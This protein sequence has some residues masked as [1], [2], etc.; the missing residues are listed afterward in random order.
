MSTSPSLSAHMDVHPAAAIFPMLS[1]V[2]LDELAADIKANGQREPIELLD[3]AILDGRNRYAACELAGV[4][5]CFRT[6]DAIESPTRYV[7]SKNLYRR[8]L[9]TGQ[10][11]FIAVEALPLLEDEARM[12][13]IQL[14]GTRPNAEQ[15]P[16]LGADLPQGPVPS[17][18]RAPRARDA[19]GAAVGIS[20]R[21][22]AK[23]KEI[24][25]KAPDLREQLRAG[26]LSLDKAA[27]QVRQREQQAEAAA[28]TTPPEIPERIEV[29]DVTDHIPLDDDSVDL[30]LT[31][32]PYGLDKPYHGIKDAAIGWREFLDDWLV[33]AFRVAK[34][35]GRLALNVPL[36]TSRGGYRATWPEAYNAA[37]AAGWQYR[38]CI[39][40]DKRNST[41]GAHGNGSLNSANAPHPIAEIEMVGLFFKDE[42]G[43]SSES[44]S[45][46]TPEEWQAWGDGVW[47]F[48]GETRPHEHHPAPFPPELPRRLIRYLTR[49]G[50]TVLDPM[51]GSGT[52][53]LVARQLNREGIGFDQAEEYVASSKRRLATGTE[54]EVAA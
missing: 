52:T 44:Y 24:M 16:D 38:T 49:V 31:S 26:T 22:V 11:A 2:E 53:V 50:D 45:D 10:K 47:R 19:A 48:P 39:V 5:P 27:H 13:Q 33:E 30:V 3:D 1:K 6:L 40:W 28:R 36:D 15:H 20:G 35:R 4:E 12:R 37:V 18:T 25:E 42:W 29:A 17:K 32:P 14:A 51:V 46:I 41:K 8:H 7:L 43:P 21:S 9:S 34:P 23:A 54:A